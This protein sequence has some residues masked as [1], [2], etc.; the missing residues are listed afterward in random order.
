MA[1]IDIKTKEEALISSRRAFQDQLAQGIVVLTAALR[2]HVGTAYVVQKDWG[3][4]ELPMYKEIHMIKDTI[5]KDGKV[6]FVSEVTL[7]E[8]ALGQISITKTTQAVVPALYEKSTELSGVFYEELIS[9]Y[10]RG[11]KKLF[12]ELNNNITDQLSI[13]RR[14]RAIKEGTLT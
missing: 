7:M 5:V 14:Q 6:F 9:K 1:Q 12:A 13:I 10:D 4:G 8:Q 11:V 3:R 2:D